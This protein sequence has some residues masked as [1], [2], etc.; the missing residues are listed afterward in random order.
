MKRSASFANSDCNMYIRIFSLSFSLFMLAFSAFL[1][2]FSSSRF[3]LAMRFLARLRAARKRFCR[4]MAASRSL[5]PCKSCSARISLLAFFA[6]NTF[7]A[8]VAACS[9][10]SSSVMWSQRV[11]RILAA[12]TAS[13]RC[14]NF[15][16][17]SMEF[18]SNLFDVPITG[19]MT[20]THRI[21]FVILE[22]VRASWTG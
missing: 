4:P 22:M 18:P 14:L 13:R 21:H 7:C 16:Y 1:S 12:L 8:R 10:A 2:S 20:L 9:L 11:L 6:R 17:S 5:L 3:L 19:P 15:L